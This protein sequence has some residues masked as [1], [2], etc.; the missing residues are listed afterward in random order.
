MHIVVFLHLIKTN[1]LKLKSLHIDN[2]F[3]LSYIHTL[4][5]HILNL[6]FKKLIKKK[7]K[8][9]LFWKQQNKIF[10]ESIVNT[11]LGNSANKWN[12]D[13]IDTFSTWSKKTTQWTRNIGSWCLLTFHTPQIGVYLPKQIFKKNSESTSDWHNAWSSYWHIYY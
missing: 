2:S 9:Y 12:V 10:I 8:I 13:V 11:L 5:Y 3:L 7:E 6:N 1:K 4:L